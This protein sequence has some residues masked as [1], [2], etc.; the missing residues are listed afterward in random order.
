MTGPRTLRH[1]LENVALRLAV[2]L[3]LLGV[4]WVATKYADSL[5]FPP[6]GDVLQA[7]SM[8]EAI[9]ELG[10]QDGRGRNRDL[11]VGE[12]FGIKPGEN[13][14]ANPQETGSFTA[15]STST[16]AGKGVL[17]TKELAIKA[18]HN[19]SINH[20]WQAGLQQF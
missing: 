12:L 3:G 14:L 20:H 10:G 1:T 13:L 17:H 15:K 19:Q 2:L 4:W 8:D 9:E 7:V 11:D 6:P 5:F 16:D 18:G